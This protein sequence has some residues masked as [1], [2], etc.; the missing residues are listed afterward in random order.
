M[1]SKR[2]ARRDKT[3][4]KLLKKTGIDVKCNAP[5][6]F[7]FNTETEAAVKNFLGKRVGKDSIAEYAFSH[8]V[9]KH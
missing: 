3:I 8:T 2:L 5:S 9:K 6:D 4:E 1:K 7:I